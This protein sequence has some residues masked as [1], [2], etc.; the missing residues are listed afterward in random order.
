MH[1][2]QIT[3]S[4]TDDVIDGLVVWWSGDGERWKKKKKGK[5]T[6]RVPGRTPRSDDGDDL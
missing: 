1:Q 3:I 4:V 2:I 5:S 6:T